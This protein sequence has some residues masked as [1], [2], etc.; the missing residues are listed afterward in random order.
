[1]SWAEKYM[2]ARFKDAG[3]HG[4]GLHCWG[5]VRLVYAQELGIELPSYGEIAA[6]ELI[7]IA[8]QIE[9]STATASWREVGRPQAFDVVLMTGP[10]LP[11]MKLRQ[12]FHVG[13]MIDEKR[14]LHIERQTG[15]T[16][17]SL[18]HPAIRQRIVGFQRH[19]SR[20]DG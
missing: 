13:V 20:P 2:G 3:E 6:D 14:L 19:R 17:P 1:M 11:G 10:A 9:R 16:A 4:P 18:T 15:V 7:R 8:R 12:P 5:L